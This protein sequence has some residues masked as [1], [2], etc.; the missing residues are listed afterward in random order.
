MTRALLVTLPLLVAACTTWDLSHVWSKQGAS[1]QQVSR[2]D[3]ECRRI[4][5]E[6]APRTPN[7]IVGGLVDAVR[8]EIDEMMR[9]ATYSDC[10]RSR[11]YARQ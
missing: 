5:Y 1:G 2:D 6:T 9:V 7:L 11:G 3:W 10:M 4:E 8:V